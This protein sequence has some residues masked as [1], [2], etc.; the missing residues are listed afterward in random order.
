MFMIRLSQSFSNIFFQVIYSVVKRNHKKNRAY[1]TDSHQMF[2]MVTEEILSPTTFATE[3]T[4]MSYCKT[5][6][7][8]FWLIVLVSSSPSLTSMRFPHSSSMNT[9]LG[10][11]FTFKHHLY[12]YN[13]V[14]PQL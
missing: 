13:L 9:S 14:L 10:E 4:S 12:Q 1:L 2:H 7:F 6:H 11:S 5:S 3:W 8:F